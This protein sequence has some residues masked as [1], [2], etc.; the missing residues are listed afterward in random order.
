MRGRVLQLAAV[1]SG[2]FTIFMQ[3]LVELLPICIST[4]VSTHTGIQY[5]N[6]TIFQKAITNR[7]GGQRE[8]VAWTGINRYDFSPAV[9]NW[10]Q[11][12]EL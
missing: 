3:I 9:A 5:I 4:G 12:N 6:M 1:L 2:Q 10:Q 7:S 8:G 11:V